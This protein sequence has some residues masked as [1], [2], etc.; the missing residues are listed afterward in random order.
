MVQIILMNSARVEV[1]QEE[2]NEFITQ[3]LI[4]NPDWHHSGLLTQEE[5]TRYLKNEASQED[6]QKVARYILIYEE[7]LA[8]TAFLFDKSEG[9]SDQGKEFNMP[10]LKKLR[11]LYQKVSE[12][13]Q[14]AG[15]LASDV[16]EMENTCLETGADPL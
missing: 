11:D 7:N 5:V 13:P 12:L 4:P 3:E 2:A 8:F 14:T 15:E 1:S 16:H 9:H 10:A 6:L